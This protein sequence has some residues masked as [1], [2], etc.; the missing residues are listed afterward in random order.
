MKKT[1][2]IITISASLA[3][4][5]EENN[6]VDCITSLKKIADEIVIVD[7]E[8]KDRTTQLAQKMGARVISTS[9]KSMFNINKNLAIK[10]CTGEWVLLMDADERISDELTQEIKQTVQGDA[11]YSGYWINRRNWFLG[12]FLKKGGAYP[13]AVIRLFRRGKGILPE[14][15]V[16]EQVEIDGEVGYL[17]NDILHFTDPSFERYLK[18]AIRYTDETAQYL[19]EKDPGRGV[20]QIINYMIV[21]PFTTFLNIYLRHKGYQDGFRGFIWAL[22][23]GAHYFYAYVKYWEFRKQI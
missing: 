20:F 5:N 13:D 15:S 7:G 10:N 18:R 14:I 3:T 4:Y 22:F 1:K 2:K 6:I 19:K 17:N 11:L 12:G 9:N 21:R 16:H 23:S 8:S